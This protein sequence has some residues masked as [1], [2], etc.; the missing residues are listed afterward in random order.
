MSEKSIRVYKTFD[1]KEIKSHLLIYGDLTGS[2]ANCSEMDIKLDATQ[3]PS[4][5]TE[6]KYIA[7]RNVKSNIPKLYKIMAERPNIQIID[8]EDY[9]RTL[10]A[11]KAQDFLK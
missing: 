5:Q 4:C 10:G 8:H 9:Q 2:C 3:C 7:F 1:V 11:Q 6:Y